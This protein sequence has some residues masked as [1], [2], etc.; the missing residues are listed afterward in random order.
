IPH[1]EAFAAAGLSS[2]RF[3]THELHA[4]YFDTPDGLL[5]RNR[6]AVRVRAGGSDAGW[7]LK[8]KGAGGTRELHWP[9]SAE[10]PAGLA[11]EL[12][13]RV[14]EGAAAIEPL[15]ELRTERRVM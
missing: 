10:M 12:R 1:G 6:L 13:E 14:G 2:G 7:H 5:A 11:N 15:A 8:E 4:R 9:I 3:V